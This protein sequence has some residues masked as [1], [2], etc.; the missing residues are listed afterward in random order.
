MAKAMIDVSV[1]ILNGDE[2]AVRVPWDA[3]VSELQA[4]VK[5]SMGKIDESV[6]LFHA[7]GELELA[8]GV[9]SSVLPLL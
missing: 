2:I 1:S 3:P 4:Q 8:Q 5:Q 7:D 9:A 6:R